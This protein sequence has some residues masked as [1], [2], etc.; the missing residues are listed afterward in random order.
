MKRPLF[1]V[2]VFPLFLNSASGQCSICTNLNSSDTINSDANI[3][4][5]INI[6]NNDTTNTSGYND[7]TNLTNP[8]AIIPVHHENDQH[9]ASAITCQGVN[10]QLSLLVPSINSS[11]DL[12]EC[13]AWIS[14]ESKMV[15]IAGYCGCQEL[16]NVTAIGVAVDQSIPDDSSCNF[17]S[18]GNTTDQDLVVDFYNYTNKS[19]Q[20]SQWTCG[21]LAELASFITD[22]DLCQNLQD[23]MP[24]C[25]ADYVAPKPQSLVTCTLCGVTA[26]VASQQDGTGSLNPGS[27]MVMGF[28]NKTIP[29]AGTGRSLG[30]QTCQ[31]IND[32]LSQNPLSV[33][34]DGAQQC[35]DERNSLMDDQEIYL[36]LPSYCGCPN[37]PA[38]RLCTFVCAKGDF[39]AINTDLVVDKLEDGTK[40][41][42]GDILSVVPYIVDFDVCQDHQKYQSLCCASFEASC[43]LCQATG[44]IDSGNNATSSTKVTPK[45][46]YP[47]KTIPSLKRSC[48]LVDQYFGTVLVNNNDNDVTQECNNYRIVETQNA[49]VDFESYC[50][51]ETAVAPST[52]EFC[53]GVD[54]M[55][56]DLV[57]KDIRGQKR[58]HH[59][60]AIDKLN[61]WGVDG[62]SMTCRSLAELIPSVTNA[63]F[64]ED[65]QYF[66]PICCQDFQPTCTICTSVAFDGATLTKPDAI[67]P[68]R[69]DTCAQV[70][71]YFHFIQ[72]NATAC[73]AQRNGFSTDLD[74]VAYCGCPGEE[75]PATCN[76][77]DL[78]DLIDPDLVVGVGQDARTCGYL[79]GMA[80]YITNQTL[81]GW[82][83]YA[84]PQCCQPKVE[85]PCSVCQNQGPMGR[86]NNVVE[87]QKGTTCAELD[88][89]IQQLPQDICTQVKADWDFDL[90]SFC[91]CEGSDAADRCELC[92]PDQV[93][94]NHLTSLPDRPSWTC[95]IGHQHAPFIADDA[96]C[97]SEINTNANIELCCEP[98]TEPPTGAPDTQQEISK[99]TEEADLSGTILWLVS[100]VGLIILMLF[101]QQKQQRDTAPIHVP[102]E[103]INLRGHNID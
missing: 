87:H 49:I 74:V 72:R 6:I 7:V 78:E 31:E 15:D 36:D 68:G 12:A 103:Q 62:N 98:E 47:E 54:L 91:G 41:T 77:C 14:Q 81:C 89:R 75:P 66:R 79:A 1:L 20:Y 17:C 99:A 73:N 28:L 60:G 86:P 92:G 40:L 18:I 61:G 32:A 59:Q 10:H 85:S 24:T 44:N 80:P 50:G 45:M 2:T 90:E 4:I 55:N 30:I 29:V 95:M 58:N 69:E 57:L 71:Q 11:D 26:R 23:L 101:L 83:E 9:N 67:I 46:L 21:N 27:L 13:E 22:T 76:F 16:E 63:T 64:C 100:F 42:C 52:C 65:L 70:D 38:P 93:L 5:N 33:N 51:C 96:I 102:E 56:P 39:D 37:S 25:C 88:Q 53:T 34:D 48:G 19:D 35:T 97:A 94:R 8:N 3:N 43:H 84:E 82:L